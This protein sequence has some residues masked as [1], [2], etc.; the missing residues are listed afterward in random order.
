MNEVLRRKWHELLRAWA[1]DSALADRTF[2]RI[3]HDYSVPGRF[4]HTLALIGFS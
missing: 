2:E 1:V 3:V 4:Y